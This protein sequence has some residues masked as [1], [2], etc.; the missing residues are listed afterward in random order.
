LTA[1]DEKKRKDLTWLN[2]F[3]K[4]LQSKDFYGQVILDFKAGEIKK[5]NQNK[6]G[7]PD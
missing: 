1:T 7:K 5:Y 3:V 6:T 2:K 4:S